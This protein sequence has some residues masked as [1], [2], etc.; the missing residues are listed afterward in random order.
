[1]TRM[2]NLRDLTL[3]EL[4][5]RRNELQQ[6]LF[7]LTLRKGVREL[8]NPLKLRTLRRDM[9][10]IATILSEDR[11]GIRKIVDQAGSLLDRKD[12]TT[13]TSKDK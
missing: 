10:R 12:D 7:N 4:L 11:N 8:D 13:K 5:Q 1:M 9:A 3:D 6:E 2:E